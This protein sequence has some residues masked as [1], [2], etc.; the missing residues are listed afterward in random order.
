MAD[1]ERGSV[2][3]I[4]T[5]RTEQALES[6]SGSLQ[7]KTSRRIDVQGESGVL[8]GL[9]LVVLVHGRVGLRRP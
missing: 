5:L 8:F 3:D 9:N 6:S 2:T 4:T 7:L 1:G